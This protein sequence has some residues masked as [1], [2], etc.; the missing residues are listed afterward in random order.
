[1]RSKTRTTTRPVTAEVNGETVLYE[2][3]YEE[4]VPK[5][6]ISP[7]KVG[8]RALMGIATVLLLLTAIWGTVAIGSV[9]QNGAPAVVAYGAAITFDT[10]WIACLLALWVARFDKRR[11]RLPK[12]LGWVFLAVSAGM[13]VTDGALKGEVAYGIAGGLLGIVAKTVWQMAMSVTGIQLDK[14]HQAY[15]TAKRQEIGTQFALAGVMA[16][17]AEL[18]ART[19]HAHLAREAQY[20]P[21]ETDARPM[22]SPTQSREIPSQPSETPA[23]KAETPAQAI[24]KTSQRPDEDVLKLV[25]LLH[26]GEELSATRAGEILNTSR[27]TGGRKL[28]TARDLLASRMIN[29]YL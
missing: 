21:R 9:L 22:S 23:R 16:E 18:E 8:K 3:Q 24:G 2:E 28:R 4:K 19:R 17:L 10:A 15:V 7:D 13:I 29:G 27:A 14:K 11:S 26:G 25:Q 12:I 20:G 5:T 1:M 6:P